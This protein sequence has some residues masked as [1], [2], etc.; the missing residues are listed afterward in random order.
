MQPRR[1]R[2]VVG[3]MVFHCERESQLFHVLEI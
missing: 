2:P 1:E 3:E